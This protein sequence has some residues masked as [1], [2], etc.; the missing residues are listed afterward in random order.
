MYDDLKKSCW[1]QN[2]RL[3]KTGLVIQTFG[4]V[5]S[6]DR[7]RG[8]MAIKPSG[9]A[10]DTMQPEDIVCVRLDDGAVVE[11]RLRPSCDTPTHL[12]LYRAFPSIGGIV[13]THS[14]YATSWAQAAKPVPLYGTTHADHLAAD[15]P[16][17]DF[18][19][20]ERV[21]G[22][23]EVETGRQIVDCFRRQGL[24]AAEIPMVLVAGH[25]PFAWGR[26]AA[27]AVDHAEVLEMLCRMALL[28]QE[29]NPAAPRLRDDLIRRHYERKHGANRTYGQQ[30]K[31]K[32]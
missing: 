22:D 21:N 16:C 4:N 15:I 10:Y 29:I 20:T 30:E 26:T 18:M 8:V 1:E 32:E 11:G 3:A 14:V 31:G 2:L 27:Q 7:A 9:V 28:T 5:S 12:V 19:P 24:D 17:T 6:A 25:G 23:Y 13:H